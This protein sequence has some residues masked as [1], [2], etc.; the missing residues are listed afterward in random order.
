MNKYGAKKCEYDGIKF[1][2]LSERDFYIHLIEIMK[3]DKK[4]IKIHPK[5]I[6]QNKF[7][8]NGN[9]YREINYIADFQ[10]GMIVYDV[11]GSL[12]TITPVAK[13]KH[14]IFIKEY[15]QVKLILAI[16]QNKIWTYFE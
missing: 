13:I 4:I 7:T 11:K 15:P 3:Y 6:L 12:S 8:H 9:Q 14:K 1:D 5:F 16:K 2:S 10:I